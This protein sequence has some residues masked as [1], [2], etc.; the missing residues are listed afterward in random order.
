DRSYHGNTVGSLAVSGQ[1][2]YSTH[3]RPLLNVTQKIRTPQLYRIQA[4][5]NATSVELLLNRLRQDFDSLDC[6]H[7]AGVFLE[8]MG[9]AASGV[10]VPPE[11]FLRELR[12]LCTSHNLL[13]ICDEVMS[14]FGR[15]GNW[16]GFQ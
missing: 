10:A 6:R 12:E 2:R 9:G 8:G 7:S 5:D 4:P 15:T 16:F 1:P 13:W 14:G 3:V 11:A